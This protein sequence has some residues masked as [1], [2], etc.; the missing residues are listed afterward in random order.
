MKGQRPGPSPVADL[1]PV[2]EEPALRPLSLRANFAW[3]LVGTAVYAGAQWG[4]TIVLAKLGS[5]Q[6][7]GQ[8][9]LGLA[10]GAP[11][12]M[13]TNLQL[14]NIQATDARDEYAFR[15]YFTL[16]MLATVC[17]LVVIGVIALLGARGPTVTLV[18][19]LIGLAK[20]VESISDV[21][22]GLWQKLER[23]DLTA[24]S[25]MIK[26]PASLVAMWLA[27]RATHDVVWAT[28]ALF[29][30]W[31]AVTLGFDFG[32]LWRL[33]RR[34]LWG[35]GLLT[36]ARLRMAR[37]L[38]LVSLPLGIVGM[39]DSLTVNVPRYFVAHQLGDAALGEFAAMAYITVFGSMIVA[40][41]AQSASPR[42]ARHY[43]TDIR[44]F[45]QLLLKLLAF[46]AAIGVVGL[47]L[48]AG[49]GRQVLS[50]IYR[51]DYATHTTAFFWLMVAAGLTYAAKFLIISMIA[52]RQF[53][54]QTPLYALMLLVIALL[55][56]WWVPT[57]G[58]LGAAYALC[59]GTLLLLVGAAYINARAIC[60]RYR[61]GDA[62]PGPGALTTG[63]LSL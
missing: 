42:L 24:L 31:T 30:T 25:M 46:G 57:H 11:I 23:L 26:G 34:E 20:C 12:V 44:A 48:V 21:V 29:A 36:P 7:V 15:D 52:A 53:R 40:A 9:A 55:C 54:A 38:A 35:G 2:R 47:L 22:W 4:M 6:M 13:L 63:G 60:C 33:A 1:L 10:I 8:Y 62:S 39:L 56:S 27:M 43:V 17:A 58:L 28:A 51:P 41:L 37:R 18:I 45:T 61:Q 14:R 49:F 3:T 50:I 32:N 5:K 16:R 19:L 59:V